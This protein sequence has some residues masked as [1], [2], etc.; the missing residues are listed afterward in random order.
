MKLR[1]SK[2]NDIKT[3]LTTK[4]SCKIILGFDNNTIL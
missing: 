2:I 4:N 1:K 3:T